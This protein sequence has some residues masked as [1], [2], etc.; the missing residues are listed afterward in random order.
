M[1]NAQ[2]IGKLKTR[3]T[4]L[5]IL[6]RTIT[7]RDDMRHHAATISDGSDSDLAD[8]LRDMAALWERASRAYV[9]PITLDGPDNWYL[10]QDHPND[11]EWRYWRSDM[12]CV[13]KRCWCYGG[14]YSLD[15][16]YT[17]FGA[18]IDAMPAALDAI[19]SEATP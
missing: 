18:A 15:D 12:L 10:R 6:V 13:G 1:S 16:S 2:E 8:R 3:V 11:D 4:E 19:E 17:T 5:E 14:G 9:K 7:L